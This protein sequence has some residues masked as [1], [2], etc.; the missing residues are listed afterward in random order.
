MHAKDGL[1]GH[2][3]GMPKCGTWAAGKLSYDDGTRR[4]QLPVQQQLRLCVMARPSTWQVDPELW[5]RIAAYQFDKPGIELPFSR[6]LAQDNGWP[7]DFALHVIEAYR[8]FVYLACI[9]DEQV[10]PSDEVEQAWRLHLIFSQDYWEE[11]CGTVLQRPFHY[12]PTASA[13]SERSRAKADYQRTLD[14]YQTTF[15]KAPPPD[16]WPPAQIR[17]D[18]DA[19]FVRVNRGLF[20]ISAREGQFW[21]RV[22]PLFLSLV[23]LYVAAI[24]LIVLIG[25]YDTRLVPAAF[26]YLPLLLLLSI[27]MILA[28]G[29][30]DILESVA[31]WLV[32]DIRRGIFW[33]PAAGVGEPAAA[34]L[35]G[36]LYHYLRACQRRCRFCVFSHR[37]W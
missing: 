1:A 5:K 18:S 7:H 4:V 2:P 26:A 29:L 23:G 15:G 10:M 37:D 24:L 9:A 12:K 22:Q 32:N 27:M 16:V 14:L 20:A 28:F 34:R 19:R 35:L 30:W 21:A 36:S 8:R 6:H 13:P 25:A 11:F 3:N 33:R 31:P 17:F